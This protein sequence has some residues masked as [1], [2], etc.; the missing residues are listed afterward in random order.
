[1]RRLAQQQKAWENE[2][3]APSPLNP[4]GRRERVPRPSLNPDSGQVTHMK[5][6]FQRL[7]EEIRDREDDARPVSRDRPPLSLQPASPARRRWQPPESLPAAA[8]DALP[9]GSVNLRSRSPSPSRAEMPNS[10]RGGAQGSVERP[11]PKP[12]SARKA[13]WEN[14][15]ARSRV[16][17]WGGGGL[18]E[19]EPKLSKWKLPF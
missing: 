5:A 14:A 6:R 4:L 1:M 9:P 12:V 8:Q 17:I 11:P 10:P 16:R 19:R 18:V 2:E 15:I 13:S 3:D 7:A